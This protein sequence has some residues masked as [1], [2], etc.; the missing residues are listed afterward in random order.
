MEEI[1]IVPNYEWCAVDRQGN[2]YS[3]RRGFKKFKLGKDRDGY[4][5]ANTKVSG[6]SVRL[7]A[8][9]AVALAFL[10]SPRGD[11]NQVNHIN[12]VRDD[13]RLENLEWVTPKRNQEHRWEQGNN[14]KV[15]GED[16]SNWKY[17][18]DLIR[19]VCSLIEQGFRNK[20]ILS[21]YPELDVKLP[22]DIRNGKSWTHVSKDYKLKQ[23]R[24]G[25]LSESTVRYICRSLEEGLTPKQIVDKSKNPNITTSVVRHIRNRVVYKDII[26]DYNF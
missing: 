9:R 1:K 3:T 16:T 18:E 19:S 11:A 15:F 8:H 5:R 23:I 14:T 21:R 26:Q 12:S 20:D 13:N 10:G 24:R 25:R 22:S 4:L 2:L 7:L 6:K 17:P